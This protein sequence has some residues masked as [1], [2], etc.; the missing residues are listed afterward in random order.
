MAQILCFRNTVG[1]DAILGTLPEPPPA[2]AWLEPLSA[3]KSPQHDGRGYGADWLYA[4]MPFEN[5]FR[6]NGREA[7]RNMLRLRPLSQLPFLQ[8]S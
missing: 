8:G 2:E 4:E 7:I 5:A 3:A 1:L 6:T